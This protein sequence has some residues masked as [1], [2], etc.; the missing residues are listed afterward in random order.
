MK[1]TKSLNEE[2]IKL[3]SELG[4]ASIH[5]CTEDEEQAISDVQ[6]QGQPI[7]GGI[8]AKKDGKYFKCT[9]NE[10]SD[11]DI[12]KLLKYRTISYLRIIRTAVLGFGTIISA[13]LVYIAILLTSGI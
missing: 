3:M 8:F 4:I 7:P 13:L 10:V 12:D 2:L 6:A 9:Y 11:E 5:R 1:K